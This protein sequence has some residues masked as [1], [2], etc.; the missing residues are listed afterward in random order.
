MSHPIAQAFYPPSYAPKCHLDELPSNDGIHELAASS[1]H[2]LTITRQLVVSY[3][4]FSPL[5]IFSIFNLQFSIFNLQSNRLAV[6]FFCHNLLSPIASIFGSGVP[7]AARTFLSCRDTSDRTRTLLSACK[8]NKK[9]WMNHIV[10][11]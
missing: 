7:Y 8:I 11:L 1:W 3:T 10:F 4:T 5:P 2:S 6:V 9:L